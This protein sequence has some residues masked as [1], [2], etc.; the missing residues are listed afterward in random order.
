[1]TD[2]DKRCDF[3]ISYTNA[4]AAWAQWIADV[5]ERAGY[6]VV[7]QARDFLSGGNFVL[8]MDAAVGCERTIAV[9]SP[10]YFES[11]YAKA[12]WAAAFR[13]D[14]TGEKNKLIPVRVADFAP[15]GLLG[16]IV[17]IDLVGLSEEEAAVKV[18]EEIAA[19]L[20]GRRM[21][22]D[23]LTFPGG[24]SGAEE[25]LFPTT[26]P[27]VWNLP[28]RLRHFFGRTGLLRTLQERLGD[29]RICV[30]TGLGGVGKSR[31]ALEY[32]HLHTGEHDII[33]RIRAGEEATASADL[34]ELARSLGIEGMADIPPAAQAEAALG[35]L[36][37]QERWLLV[38]EDAASPEAA[39]DLIPGGA[40]GRILITT[41]RATGWST[42]GE[43]IEVAPLTESEAV[44]FIRSR[45]DGAP[46]DEA[47][48][49]AAALGS[50]P[51]ALEQASAYMEA[52]G[53]GPSEYVGRLREHSP[54]LFAS[55]RP[56]DYELTVASTW[57]LAM[58]EVEANA[59]A[60]TLLRLLPSLSPER[61]PRGLFDGGDPRFPVAPTLDPV[62]F[63]AAIAELRRF[64]LVGLAAGELSI[65]R[66]V[67]WVVRQ[68]QT[69]PGRAEA[70]ETADAIL[71]EAWPDWD[72]REVEEWPACGALAVHLEA[73]A[74]LG[75]EEG[76]DP[77]R[78]AELLSSAAVYLRARGDLRAARS[79]LLEARELC[80]HESVGA[81]QTIV[82]LGEL[83]VVL[84]G[85]GDRDGALEAQEGAVALLEREGLGS[86]AI[87][88]QTYGFLGIAL[89]ELGELTRAEEMH[90]K[91]VTFYREEAPLDPH[92]LG[93]ALGNLGNV[94]RKA[95]NLARA[96]KLQEESVG[97]MEEAHGPE[98]AEVGISLGGLARVRRASGDLSGARESLS[99]ALEI[100]RSTFG[101]QSLEVA[102][103]QVDLGAVNGELGR[104]RESVESFEEAASLYRAKVGD[105]V[106]M[107]QPALEG[108]AMS[109]A[110]LG[111]AAGAA[112]ASGEA[113][114]LG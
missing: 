90:E 13:E 101:P 107:L 63:D 57:R 11:D 49:L 15:G 62:E 52:T 113:R 44:D 72:G 73:H 20:A 24:P 31:T 79:L 71:G 84:T 56:L 22:K 64:S 108:L 77:E 105:G 35:W 110:A 12:E 93:A 50:L 18:V 65:H 76:R 106:P 5:V 86:S 14:P 85:L 48:E 41:R 25:L 9:I 112:R 55:G 69:E 19:I 74:R 4:D 29:H 28:V 38:L 92:S 40:A 61:I 89:M 10:A 66:L 26:L 33:W 59:G 37:G 75:V 94:V 39:R 46:A 21:P 7:L 67:Q 114:Q 8:D 100:F 54:K 43:A 16:S 102:R 70:W 96:T 53:I 87:A 68:A 42:L 78:V 60:A 34:A 88:G 95:G 2:R 17:Y 109:R 98:G 103:T 58:I 32:A 82:V 1:M 45:A 104:Y 97:L 111:D 51:L 80:E 27:R 30:L 3:F 83:G 81:E 47:A 36:A 99:K 91:A 6:S 23:D